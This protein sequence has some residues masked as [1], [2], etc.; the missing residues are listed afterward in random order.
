MTLAQGRLANG[1]HLIRVRH[2]DR[3]LEWSPWS[4]P[5]AFSVTGSTQAFTTVTTGRTRYPKGTQIDVQWANGPGNATDWVGIYREGDK[6]GTG[7]GSTTWKYTPTASGSTTFSLSNSNLYWVNVFE[8]G[9][10]KELAPRRSFYYGDIPALTVAQEQYDVGQTVAVSLTNGPALAGDW[11]G[12]YKAGKVPNVDGASVAWSYATSATGTFTFPSLGSGFYY[13]TYMLKG[14]YVEP[15]DRVAFQVGATP[16]SL[17]VPAGSF[18]AGAPVTF[19]FTDGPAIPK[20]YIGIFRQGA[21][22]ASTSWLPMSTSRARRPG[23]PRPRGSR[24]ETTLPRSTRT[25]ATPK[26]PTASCSR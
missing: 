15:G 12:V 26:Y 8:N 14:G 1:Q 16:A 20:D 19:Y 4:E 22:P 10:Y 13:A 3:N 9:G 17:S 7:A 25:T 18:P 24:P 23:R 21:T 6:P 11:V 2:R 5:V